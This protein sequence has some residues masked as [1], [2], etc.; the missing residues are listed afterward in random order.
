MSGVTPYPCDAGTGVPLG[1]HNFA[2]SP[3]VCT[4]CGKAA[5]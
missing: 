2:G 5:R 4:L 3:A 1:W